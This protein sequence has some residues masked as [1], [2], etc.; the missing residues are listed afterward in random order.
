MREIRYI[1]QRD[2][3]DRVISRESRREERVVKELIEILAKAVVD[4]PEEVT[5]TEQEGTQYS[6]IQLKVAKSDIGKVIGRQGRMIQAIRTLLNAASTNQG[7][8]TFL[9]LME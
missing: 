4:Q 9:E 6:V 2:R 5:V 7:K 3:S 1:S 8:Y